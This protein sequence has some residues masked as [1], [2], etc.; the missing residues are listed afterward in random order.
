MS[1]FWFVTWIFLY[2]D[3]LYHLSKV[4]VLSNFFFFFVIVV[5]VAVANCRALDYPDPV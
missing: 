3:A 5:V 2:F 4:E 1:K